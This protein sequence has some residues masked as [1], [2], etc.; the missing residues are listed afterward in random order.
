MSNYTIP[1]NKAE[2]DDLIHALRHFR[3]VRL[4]VGK[5]VADIDRYLTAIADATVGA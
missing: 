3:A 4:E 1:T 2:R 5:S